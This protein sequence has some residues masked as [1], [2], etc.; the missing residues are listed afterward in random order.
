MRNGE[1]FSALLFAACVFSIMCAIVGP[2]LV[3]V[4][5]TQQLLLV[6]AT[7]LVGVLGTV[8]RPTTLGGN[9]YLRDYASGRCRDRAIMLGTAEYA[10]SLLADARSRQCASALASAASAFV[11]DIDER[12][13][14]EQEDRE[15]HGDSASC[16]CDERSECD[17]Q[18]GERGERDSG[19]RNSVWI[20]N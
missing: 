20:M 7:L 19:V 8:H 16:E 12:R 9:D 18:R 5:S 15:R 14:D 6:A 3:H 4:A 10:W 1:A 11:E 17:H 13:R 2:R